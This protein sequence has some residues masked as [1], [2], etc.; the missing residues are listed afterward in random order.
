M[1]KYYPHGVKLSSGQKEKLAKA[2]ANNS[3]TTIRLNRNEFSGNDE[4]MLTKTQ[5]DKLE[6]SKLNGTGSDIKISKT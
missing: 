2:Y 4:L 6:K 3:A 1:T 5:I